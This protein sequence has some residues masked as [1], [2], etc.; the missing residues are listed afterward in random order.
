MKEKELRER[1][2]CANCGTKI[3]TGGRLPVFHVVTVQTY[4]VDLNAV[5]RQAGMEMMMGGH[6]VLAQVMGSDEDMAEEIGKASEFTICT[7][8]WGESLLIAGLAE[9]SIKG[10]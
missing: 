1:A 4:G 7:D 9:N 8:C 3:C 6:V 5:K 2:V 10:E